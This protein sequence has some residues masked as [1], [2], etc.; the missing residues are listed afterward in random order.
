M[1]R[2]AAAQSANSL[3]ARHASLHGAS[4]CALWSVQH[5]PYYEQDYLL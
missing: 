1:A 5:T 4:G 2:P 3:P